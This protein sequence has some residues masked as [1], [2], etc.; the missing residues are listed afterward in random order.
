M[1]LIRCGVV[2]LAVACLGETAV[3]EGDA[4]LGEMTTGIFLGVFGDSGLWP[5]REVVASGFVLSTSCFFDTLLRGI[6]AVSRFA[7]I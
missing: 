7:L 1:D 5:L 4:G 6:S 3:G 2:G